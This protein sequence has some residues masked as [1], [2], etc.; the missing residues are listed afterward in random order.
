VG[1]H[2][3]THF[4]RTFKKRMDCSPGEFAKKERAL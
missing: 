1:F 4:I 3:M 2:N